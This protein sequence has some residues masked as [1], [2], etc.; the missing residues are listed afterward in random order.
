MERLEEIQVP[1]LIIIGELDQPDFCEIADTLAARIPNAEKAVIP[2][3]AH[4]PSMEEPEQFNRV[5]LDF[6]GRHSP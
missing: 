1:T 5:V 2:G 4:L 6:L 3:V